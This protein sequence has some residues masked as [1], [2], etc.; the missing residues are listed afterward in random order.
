MKKLFLKILLVLTLLV[1]V[2]GCTE[3]ISTDE[4]GNSKK[5]FSVAE[6]AVVNNTKIRINSVKKILKECSWKYD[7]VC[8][9]YNEPDNDY[10]LIIDATIENTNEEEMS[11]SSMLSFELKSSTGEKG[12]YA[13]LTENI[14]SQLDGGIMSGDLLKGQIAYDVKESDVYYFYYQKSLLDDRIKFIINSS[15]IVE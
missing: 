5:E 8:Q 1:I 3:T 15:D 12:K 6:T 13:F 10:F 9:S 7:G 2:T 14:T 11:V 4:E